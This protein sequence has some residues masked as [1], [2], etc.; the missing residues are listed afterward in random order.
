MLKDFFDL[1]FPD[2]CISCENALLKGEK[3]IC[4][5]CMYKLPKTDFHF[6][7][8][9]ELCRKLWGRVPL[10]YGLAYLKFNK[11]GLVQNIMHHIKYKDASEAAVMLGN[12]YGH[13]L[14]KAGY[15][16]KFD[17]IIPVPL[18][19]KKLRKRGYNQSACFA[20]GLSDGLAINYQENILERSR[21]QSSQTNKN[22]L[23]RW[24]NVKEIYQLRENINL[25]GKKILLAD[26]V[27]TTGATLEVCAQELFKAGAVEV[28]VAVIA[29][30]L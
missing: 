24:S 3:N 17:L 26:D 18:H 14:Y 10:K 19:K 15:S 20:M 29:I 8:D 22:R 9:N 11:G 7:E 5:G 12:W 1:V 16:E 25:T 23:D 28:S 4:I 27:A 30:A 13:D 21:E 2:I 6:N